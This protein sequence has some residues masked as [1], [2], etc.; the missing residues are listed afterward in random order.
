[1]KEIGYIVFDAESRCSLL[2]KHD[3]L[4]CTILIFILLLF[5]V[6]LYGGCFGLRFTLNVL[7]TIAL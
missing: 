3:V 2:F 1:M 7:S 5:S 4:S 6:A